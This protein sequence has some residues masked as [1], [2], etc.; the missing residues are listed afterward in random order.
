MVENDFPAFAGLVEKKREYSVRIAAGAGSAVEM[1]S[2]QDPGVIRPDR[3]NLN[4]GKAQRAHFLARWVSLD[5]I[6]ENLGVPFGHRRANE[7][8]RLG[9][10]VAL[11]E[12]GNVAAIP[13]RDLIVENLAY[14]GLRRSGQER[15]GEEQAEQP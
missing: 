6:R 13:G 8:S 12:G 3:M 14:L 9:I 11:H 10:I 15:N 4:I 7:S 1:K 2:S 5:V